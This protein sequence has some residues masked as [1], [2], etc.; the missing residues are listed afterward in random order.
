M[1]LEFGMHQ[2][3]HRVCVGLEMRSLNADL[4]AV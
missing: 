4:E 3:I 1:I 2:M